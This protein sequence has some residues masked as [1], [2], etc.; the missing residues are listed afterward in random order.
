M[1]FKQKL[2]K[3]NKQNKEATTSEV[4][5]IF[6]QCQNTTSVLFSVAKAGGME[7]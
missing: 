4:W 7:L 3:S 2:E 1:E 5:L 6:H